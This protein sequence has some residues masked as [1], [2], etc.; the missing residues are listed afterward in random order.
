MEAILPPLGETMWTQEE[1]TD[2][3]C[4]CECINHMVA[5]RSALIAEEEA[6]PRPDGKALAR[7][8]REIDEFVRERKKL[9][10]RDHANVARINNEYGALLRER[11]QKKVKVA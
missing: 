4:A 7:L 8:N 2:Y 5:I 11:G 1:I 9:R 10:F 3:E 6:K